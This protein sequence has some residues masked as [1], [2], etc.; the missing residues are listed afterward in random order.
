MFV[1]SSIVIHHTET[2]QN[3]IKQIMCGLQIT[4]INLKYL[5]GDLVYILIIYTSIMESDIE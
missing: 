1:L 2:R 4:T 3:C 5:Y